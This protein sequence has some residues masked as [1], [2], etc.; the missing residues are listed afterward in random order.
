M[1]ENEYGLT[2]EQYHAGLAK[3]WRA[4]GLT[5]VQD[6]D[7]F[8]LAAR[9]IT[10]QQATIAKLRAEPADTTYESFRAANVRLGEENERLKAELDAANDTLKR[11]R[12]L[13]TGEVDW[14]AKQKKGKQ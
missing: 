9:R 14:S 10:E 5:T 6:E 1:S 4:L 12:Y 2:P 13:A 11:Y 8:T 7:V 3:L